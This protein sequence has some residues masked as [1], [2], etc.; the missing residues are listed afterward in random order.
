M[1]KFIK[2]IK[3]PEEQLSILREILRTNKIIDLN[4]NDRTIFIFLEKNKQLRIKNA[5]V[6][7][8]EQ[9]LNVSGKDLLKP[10]SKTKKETRKIIW[11][12]E[13][14]AFLKE[15]LKKMSLPEISEILNKSIYQIQTQIMKLNLIGRNKWTDE[16]LLFLKNNLN[17]SNNELAITLYRS[18]ASIK[19]KKKTLEIK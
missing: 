11:T 10:M 4:Y 2:K 13:E 6:D 7:L 5:E 9:L 3:L 18:I 12:D 19:S 15:N 1:E 17:L 8:Y 16:E 14:I